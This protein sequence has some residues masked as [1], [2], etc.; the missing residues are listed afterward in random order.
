MKRT[1]GVVG[2]IGIAAATTLYHFDHSALGLTCALTGILFLMCLLYLSIKDPNSEKNKASPQG[3]GGFRVKGVAT[4]E[5]T[6]L[7][8]KAICDE[9]HGFVTFNDIVRDTNL[10]L[11]TINKALDWLF[12]NKFATETKGHNGKVYM[13]TPEG[14][15]V[16]SKLI[17]EYL[18]AN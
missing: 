8:V 17:N 7:V 1:L 16:F 5:N 2:A 13:L 11:K 12:I 10:P 15:S 18:N 4:D 9:S 6:R 14:K 3:S